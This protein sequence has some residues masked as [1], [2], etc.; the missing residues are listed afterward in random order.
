MTSLF[1]TAAT[2]LTDNGWRGDDD[3]PMKATKMAA[4]SSE[5]RRASMGSPQ[6]MSRDGERRSTG[7]GPHHILLEGSS[8]MSSSSP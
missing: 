6:G 4:R 5:A 3:R 2:G 7:H 8:V 1:V